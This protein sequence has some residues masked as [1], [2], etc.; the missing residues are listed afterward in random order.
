MYSDRVMRAVREMIYLDYED[1]SKDN[2]IVKM[3]RRKILT[4][5]LEHKGILG[6]TG[7]I[8]SLIDEI[9]GVDLKYRE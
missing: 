6:Q 8:L 4:Y 9:Y 5:C 7:Y 1:T 3:P 2:E